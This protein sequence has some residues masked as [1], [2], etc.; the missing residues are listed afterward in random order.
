M[1]TFIYCTNPLGQVGGI[2]LELAELGFL[3]CMVTRY[4]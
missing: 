3:K 2:G 1:N 4:Y